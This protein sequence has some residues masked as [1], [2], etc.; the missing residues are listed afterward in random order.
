MAKLE[1]IKPGSK[2][3]GIIPNILAEIVSVEWIGE[4][5]INVVFRDGDAK[6]AETTLYRDDEHRLSL[7][8]GG[9]SWSFDADEHYTALSL[10]LFEKT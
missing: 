5:A 7:E 6:I 9:R 3:Q 8:E 10:P 1:D 4:Q 2:A